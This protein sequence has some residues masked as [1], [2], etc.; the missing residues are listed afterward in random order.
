MRVVLCDRRCAIGGQRYICA[1]RSDAAAHVGYRRIE[2]ITVTVV[3][4]ASIDDKI[5]LISNDNA[6]CEIVTKA[7]R[8]AVLDRLLPQDLRALGD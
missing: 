3:V 2:G 6:R 1:R 7:C 8:V 4:A 5:H